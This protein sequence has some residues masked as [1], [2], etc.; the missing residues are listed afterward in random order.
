MTAAEGERPDLAAMLGQL[1]RGLIAA[2][3][4]VLAAHGVSMWGYVV[5][6]ALE[7]CPASTQ[8][9]LAKEIGADKTRII[10]TLDELQ[11][12]GLIAREPDPADRRARLLHITGSGRALRAAVRDRIQANENRLLALLPAGQRQPFLRALGTLSELSEDEITGR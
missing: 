10:G 12:A 9:A 6:N 7:R 2:E 5:L 11:E 1:V 3:R 4:P 8:A